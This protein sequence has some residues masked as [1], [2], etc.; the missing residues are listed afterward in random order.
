MRP[1]VLVAGLDGRGLLLEATV[2]KRD[3]HVVEESASG[4]GVVAA[5][6]DRG[7][8]LVVL[9]PRL[10]DLSLPETIRRIRS[11]PATR[12]VSVLA[13][14][15]AGEPAAL[16]GEAIRAGANAVLRRP[17][18]QARLDTWIAK[19][20][21]VPRRVQARVPVL[22]QVVGTPRSAGAGHFVG[23]SR[24]ISV[25]GMLLA[26]PVRLAEAPDVELELSLPETAPLKALGRV[27][28]EAPEVGWPYVGYGIEFLFVTPESQEAIV[29]LVTREAA[30]SA[31]APPDEDNHQIR[32]TVRREQWIYEIL[33]PI[34]VGT[35]WQAEIRRA[36][37]ESWRPGTGGPFYV[38]E[39]ASPDDALA[40]ARDFV[41]RHG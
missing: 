8:R 25:N 16:D 23:L 4:R 13:L 18:E 15:P 11:D 12:N 38:V 22:G 29:A 2:L 7:G 14:V 10:T 41:Q 35:A 3:G 39:G 6:L 5:L 9:G 21:T 28:R 17:L 27:V 1:P 24:N 37:R 19:L 36:A 34:A 40:M 31:P 26:S 33:E 30:P 20:L 32:V